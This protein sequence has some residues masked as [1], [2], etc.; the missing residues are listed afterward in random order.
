MY[1][2]EINYP[3]QK[4]GRFTLIFSFVLAIFFLAIPVFANQIGPKNITT[5]TDVLPTRFHGDLFV[6]NTA[7]IGIPLLLQARLERDNSPSYDAIQGET[8]YFD[9]HYSDSWHQIPDDG[10]SSTSLT[11]SSAGIASVY[12]TPPKGFTPDSYSIRARYD[13]SGTYAPTSLSTTLEIFKPQWL[14]MVYMAADNN[15]EAAG[16]DDFYN[17][18]WQARNNDNLSICV[19]FDRSPSYSTLS[20]NWTDTRFFRI[21][22]DT[23]IWNYLGD[24]ERNMGDPQTLVDFVGSCRDYIDAENEALIIWDHGGG[25]GPRAGDGGESVE[26]E[27]LLETRT[28]LPVK[29]AGWDYSS[30]SDYLTTEE[31]RSALDDLEQTGEKLELLGFDACMMSMVEVAYDLDNKYDVMVASEE[32]EPYDGWPY[33]L[34]LPQIGS[35]TT[36]EQLGALI[37]NVFHSYST[38]DTTLAAIRS[39]GVASLAEQVSILAG[40]LIELLPENK[41]KIAAAWT[42]A[43]SFDWGYRDL[44]DLA[45]EIGT[46]IP[47]VITATNAVKAAIGAPGAGPLLVAE[48]HQSSYSGAHG[49]SIYF[50]SSTSDYHSSENLYNNYINEGTTP[51]NLLFVADKLWNEFLIVYFNGDIPWCTV[52][53]PTTSGWHRGDMVV[54]ANA[55]DSTSDIFYVEFEYSLD[56]SNWYDLP[57]P[58]SADGKDRDGDD[59][60]SLTFRTI[61]TP[62]HDTITDAS[63]W[64]RARSL[65]QVGNQSVWSESASF[66]VDNT[67]PTFST[68]SNTTDPIPGV[69]SMRQSII[70][71]NS[72]VLDDTTYPQFYYRYGEGESWDG[73][74]NGGWNGSSYDANITVNEDKEGETI[75]WQV[76]AQD[77]VGNEGW[78]ELYNG[79]VIGDDD[80]TGPIFT[81]YWDSGDQPA[82]PYHFKIRLTDPRGVLDDNTYP[83]IYYRWNNDL[84]DDSH[85]DGFI[86]ADWDGSWYTATIN[87]DVSHIGDTIYW[88]GYAADEDNSPASSWGT[89]QTGGGIGCQKLTT[90]I[91]P[92]GGG[93]IEASPPPNCGSSYI[94]GTLVQLTAN[95]AYAYIFDS[96]SGDALGSANPVT[97]TMDIGKS[98]TAIFASKCFSLSAGVDPSGS[99]SVDAD[100]SPN[101][102]SQYLI[103]TPVRLT[104]N[105]AEGYDFY[106]WTGDAL[107]SVNP[108][109]ITI[110]ADKAVTA[111]M[112]GGPDILLVDDDDNAPDALSYYVG[113]L[114]SIGAAYEIWDTVNNG[115]E[116]DAAA[117]NNYVTVV[118]FSGDAAGGD[119]GP[120]SASETD[121]AAWL[122]TGGCL[123]LSSQNYHSDQG[124]T[125]FMHYYLGVSSVTDDVNQ[126]VVTGTG[127]I[128]ENL[129][130][131][132]LNF[133]G[134]NNSDRIMPDGTAETAFNGDN[135]TAAIDKDTGTYR[136]TFWGFPFEAIP[137]AAG[138][139]DAMSAFL[140]WCGTVGPLVYESNAIDDD[141]D[142]LSNGNDNGIIDC[143]E[144]IEFDVIL[145]NQGTITATG[146]S[147]N[148][149]SNDPY[150]TFSNLQGDY[151][152]I[153]G[154]GSEANLGDYVFTIDPSTPDGHIVDLEL[155]IKDSNGDPWLDHFEIQVT[156]IANNPLSSVSSSPDFTN[157]S[158]IPISFSVTNL[159]RFSVKE[160]CLYY[161]YESTEWAVSSCVDSDI[162]GTL[163]FDPPDG[164]GTYY[165]K[166]IITDVYEYVETGPFGDGDDYTLYDTAEPTTSIDS[167]SDGEIF[168]SLTFEV[169]WSAT[170]PDPAS[171]VDLYQVQ[172]S[173]DG[174]EWTDWYTATHITTATFGP[175]LPNQP[176]EKVQFD[177]TYSFRARAADKA[178]NIGNYCDTISIVTKKYEYYLPFINNND[179]Y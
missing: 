143:G 136:T 40:Q 77:N 92:S 8:V 65:N 62:I 1:S 141:A 161:K 114:D 29:G 99:G 122:D 127:T 163:N 138:R 28:Q 12:Y 166:T 39:S 164:D 18:M 131:Y 59:G 52:T 61:N 139:Q 151:P 63:V 15:L 152:N 53:Q 178:G 68:Y 128:F 60:W 79:G 123:L 94:S 171:G 35:T 168:R 109:T 104:A 69:Y 25:W 57:G 147:A 110:D 97:V 82:G 66:G 33:E 137:S 101:C 84:I 37:V 56:H 130:P 70:D 91:D 19:L 30:N 108:V 38:S 100:P 46:R 179:P 24:S 121:L 36:T 103:G 34:I 64:I 85:Y 22:K 41:S 153:A 172:Y 48:A 67:A 115:D 106:F 125:D 117:M 49:I 86:N 132:A 90:I 80:T 135:G 54:S 173:M 177:H 89:T 112:G 98:V 154:G 133:P 144:T 126:T 145:E 47:S 134:A 116:P 149:V 3:S 165:F 4:L 16:V 150:I 87:I 44:Y 20:G 88:R 111:N 96:W 11:T 102:G 72:G 43:Q 146:V 95:P 167:P 157:K 50:P 124:L 107:G 170:D 71:V 27:P 75:Y 140:N 2:T 58:D 73:W 81:E 160:V 158:P 45:D 9:I 119:A 42:A 6:A 17:E 78:S 26:D 120:D 32:D 7:K 74:V 5:E 76:L 159:G 31:L 169:D 83:R 162:T 155:N 55:G 23:Q 13:G 156:C 129:G 176:G 118:W 142:G 14:F 175:D 10:N 93:S 51:A 174:G 105:A 148:L 21:S 113:A